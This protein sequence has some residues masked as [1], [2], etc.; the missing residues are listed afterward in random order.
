M[1]VIRFRNR[2][3]SFEH[4]DFYCCVTWLKEQ[5]LPWRNYRM[6]SCR[7]WNMRYMLRTLALHAITWR[8]FETSVSLFKNTFSSPPT[9]PLLMLSIFHVNVCTQRI[10]EGWGNYQYDDNS[11]LY[12]QK[13]NDTADESSD[14]YSRIITSNLFC[15]KSL[16]DKLD[17]KWRRRRK[18]SFFFRLLLFLRCLRW[19]L[20]QAIIRQ[21]QQKHH[22]Q[23]RSSKNKLRKQNWL[24]K[25]ILH[26]PLVFHL[27][28]KNKFK[29][30]C[31]ICSI[32]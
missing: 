1:N 10:D 8:H 12:I 24:D 20:P 28:V 4:I 15:R 29:I 13:H 21:Q 2:F 19:W 9:P 32:P 5:I 31:A 7:L 16:C 26:F 17:G 27:F 14:Q 6:R 25:I 22:Q 11:I 23:R 3:F 30:S 18:K